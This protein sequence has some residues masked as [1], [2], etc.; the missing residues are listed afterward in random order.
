MLIKKQPMIACFTIFSAIKASE[1]YH[2]FAKLKPK[3]CYNQ[4]GGL[5]ET[6]CKKSND[7]PLLFDIKK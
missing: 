2:G 6:F 1:I 7:T 5:K 4:V 3:I